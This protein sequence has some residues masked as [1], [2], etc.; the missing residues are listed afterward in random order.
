M[1]T[2]T[3]TKAPARNLPALKA[4]R[5]MCVRQLPGSTKTVRAELKAKIADYD[6]RIAAAA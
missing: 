5:T 1:K 4:R 2:K 3:V 6:L